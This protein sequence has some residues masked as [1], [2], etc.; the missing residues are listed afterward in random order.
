M[1]TVRSIER[2]L[3][4][5]RQQDRDLVSQMATGTGEVPRHMEWNGIWSGYLTF[6]GFAVLFMSFVWGVGFS[7]LNPM[8]ASSW[9]SVG[10][11]VLGWSVV[12]LLIAMFI[13]AWVA[14]RTPRTSKRHGMMRGIVLWGMIMATILFI[15]G[16][17][18]GTAVSAVGS[19]AGPA[20][21]SVAHGRGAAIQGTL[22]ANGITITPAQATTISNQMMAGNRAGA[23]S[24]LAADANISTARANTLLGQVPP[25][26][27]AGAASSAGSAV[28]HGASGAAWGLFV[29]ALIGLGCVLL[30]GAIGGGGIGRRQLRPSSQPA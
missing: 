23:A 24:M 4:V 14:G 22:N 13:G 21:S 10:G 20:L 19:M 6:I 8:R 1:S 26:P 29:L 30:G 2:R 17:I 3:Y 25:A 11:G 7:S 27:T 9:S 15:A 16:S 28:K 18:A 12:M 5:R